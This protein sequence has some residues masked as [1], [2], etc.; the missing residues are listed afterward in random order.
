[1]WPYAWH[2]KHCL[3]RQ[4]LSYRS[5]WN[6]WPCQMSPSSMSLLASSAA[7]ENSTTI[8]DAVFLLAD[9]VSQPI[10]LISAVGM[11]ALLSCS[12]SSLIS[13]KRSMSIEL[14]LM[15]CASTPKVGIRTAAPLPMRVS[16][17][18][19]TAGP[20]RWATGQLRLTDSVASDMNS[21]K[22]PILNRGRNIG[23][24]LYDHGTAAVDV[25][26][27]S[28]SSENYHAD[29]TSDDGRGSDDDDTGVNCHQERVV[30]RAELAESSLG[31]LVLHVLLECKFAAPD[32]L[33]SSP[34]AR[35]SSRRFSS[36]TSWFLGW[37]ERASNR[38]FI[39]TYPSI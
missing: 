6:T 16:L 17:P 36:R 9:R 14:L 4:Y 15:P 18:R 12:R 31:R 11:K 3:R 29:E 26:D 22:S 30:P 33:E 39:T 1:M 27:S 24:I 7:F 5:H 20:A 21:C 28:E 10:Y 19:Q 13:L 34:V 2:L 32:C 35:H 8:D 25:E 37:V 38:R 23:L